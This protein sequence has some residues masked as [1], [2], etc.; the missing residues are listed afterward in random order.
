L[1]LAVVEEES[2]KAKSNH[3]TDNL[4]TPEGLGVSLETF[5]ALQV[6]AVQSHISPLGT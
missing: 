6:S 5:S 3:I 1:A 2:V 4:L